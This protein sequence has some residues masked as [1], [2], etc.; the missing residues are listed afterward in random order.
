MSVIRFYVAFKYIQSFNRIEMHRYW[1]SLFLLITFFNTTVFWI[2]K[3][4]LWD[5]LAFDIQLV[6]QI[7]ITAS[8]MS[9]LVYLILGAKG[10]VSMRIKHIQYS[11]FFIFFGI[12]ALDYF[13]YQPTVDNHWR[14]LLFGLTFAL[15]F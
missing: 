10:K 6:I 11:L 3:S 15:L 9:L 4:I 7:V 12:A 1:R 2:L 13:L 8:F 5:E 14:N